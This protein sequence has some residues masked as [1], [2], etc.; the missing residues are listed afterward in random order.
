MITQR[1]WGTYTVLHKAFNHQVKSITVDPGQRLSYQTHEHRAEYWVITEGHGVVTLN[2]VET[3]C[4]VGDAFIV[5]IGDAHRIS[6]T[7]TAPL[8]FIE[9]QL[10]AV[11]AE[12]DIIRLDDDYG[13]QSATAV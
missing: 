10:G 3:P 8:T 1:P 12:S 11:L 4:L 13:R 2:G 9:T 5:E 6:N 7:G